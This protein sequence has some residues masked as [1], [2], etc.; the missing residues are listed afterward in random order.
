MKLRFAVDNIIQLKNNMWAAVTKRAL[1]Y[2]LGVVVVLLCLAPRFANA[3]E[4][5][6]LAAKIAKATGLKA[7][8]RTAADFISFDAEDNRDVAHLNCAGTDPISLRFLSPP[9]P[10]GDWYQFVGLASSPSILRA[11]NQE[12][13]AGH[14]DASFAVSSDGGTGQPGAAPCVAVYTA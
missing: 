2:G 5:E 10:N 11:S 12:A 8:K 3:D 14:A 7:D 4:C 9:N 1:N 6:T 13:P